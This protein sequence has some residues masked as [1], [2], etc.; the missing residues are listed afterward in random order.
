MGLECISCTLS[1]PISLYVTQTHTEWK[2]ETWR[3]GDTYVEAG[4]I[5]L[6][7]KEGWGGG[8]SER[9]EEK[10]L[11]GKKSCGPEMSKLSVTQS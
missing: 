9:W 3:E 11:M 2:H 5:S 8:A 6:S 1:L 10:D 4:Y 7:R